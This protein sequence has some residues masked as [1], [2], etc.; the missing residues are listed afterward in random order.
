MLNIVGT[1]NRA[2]REWADGP[3]GE[4]RNLP[5]WGNFQN[6]CEITGNFYQKVSVI[7]YGDCDATFSLTRLWLVA[8]LPGMRSAGC[9]IEGGRETSLYRYRWVEFNS[10]KRASNYLHFFS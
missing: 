6:D 1:S 4:I 9:P 2:G 10:T 3:D 5:R 7:N 8:R